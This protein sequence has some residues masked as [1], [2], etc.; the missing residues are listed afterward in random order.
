MSAETK[1]R[2]AAIRGPGKRTLELRTVV[3]DILAEFSGPMSTRQL[4][5]QAVSRG[6]V[7]NNA[8]SYD[9]VQR[10]LVN[11][12]RE[13]LV[14]Y[15][16]IVDRTRAMHQRPG[17]EGA[18]EVLRQAAHQYRRNRW[19][20]QREVVMIGCEKQALEGIFAEAVDHYGASLWTV[21]GFPSLAYVYEWAE[22]IKAHTS[23]GQDVIVYYFGDHDPS[24]LSIASKI[25]DDLREHGACFGWARRGLLFEDFD[26][27]NLIN[28]PVKNTDSRAAEYL[29]QFGDRAAELD[30]LRPD[31]LQRRIKACIVE[32]IDA[33]SWRRLG[34]VEDAERASISSVVDNW[35]AIVRSFGVA[36]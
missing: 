28:V 8:R 14:P 6:A 20:E 23:E 7:E 19:T 30:A 16:R 11:M 5:Y 34:D 29:R 9:R 31:E 10:V 13:G 2:P 15:D 1:L 25:R 33:G 22:T 12:R 3:L 24:G 21:R 18:Q 26:R 36:Q 27:F 17:W 32:H 4:Y 35:D